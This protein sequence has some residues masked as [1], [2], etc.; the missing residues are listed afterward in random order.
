MQRE[1]LHHESSLGVV[2]VVVVRLVV[3]GINIYQSRVVTR[4]LVDGCGALFSIDSRRTWKIRD[5][6]PPVERLSLNNGEELSDT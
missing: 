4:G 3:V 1:M 2:E 6:S 5:G